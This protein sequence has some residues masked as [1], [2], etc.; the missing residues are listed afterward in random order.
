[1][2]RRRAAAVGFL[3]AALVRTAGAAEV[4]DRT[5]RAVALGERTAVF[6]DATIADL[7]ITGSD[8]PDLA[9][10]IVRRAPSAAALALFPVSIDERPDGVHI[11]VLQQ[12]EGRDAALKSSITIAAPSTATFRAVRV[13][14][15][16]ITLTH[17]TAACDVDLRR[18]PIEAS[19]LAGR[20]RLEAGIGRVDVKGS[21]LDPGGMMRL[22]VF[23][24]LVRVRFARPPAVG[25][26][27][28][29]TLNGSL[30]S[31][32]PLTKKDRFG[33]RFGETT[34]GTADPRTD[35][36]LSIDVVKGD[37][38]IKVEPDSG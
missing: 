25:R 31:D 20:I 15:G 17:L 2:A 38:E 1:M 23:N 11:S 14:E 10:T 34:L 12:D 21:T 33:P 32:I 36:V 28:A 9:V 37:I 8:R 24:G 19:G 3:L 35:P 4:V 13:F 27:L 6:V 5:S 7:T 22:R 29:V 18:G 26:I 30:T 16:R